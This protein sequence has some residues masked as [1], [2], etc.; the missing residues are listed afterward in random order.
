MRLKTRVPADAECRME[1][2]MND[3]NRLER[4]VQYDPARRS[5]LEVFPCSRNMWWNVGAIYK[6][7]RGS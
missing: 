4:G 2:L 3:Q 1:D 7:G 6:L 5:S